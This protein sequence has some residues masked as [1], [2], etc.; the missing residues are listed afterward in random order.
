MQ[1]EAAQRGWIQGDAQAMYNSAVEESFIWLGVTD[2]VA[3]ADDY[4]ASGNSIV[5]W[6]AATDKTKL[7]VMQKYLALVGVNNF[8]AWVDYRRLGVPDVP[9]SLSPSRGNNKIPLRLKYPQDEYNYNAANVAAENNP[10]PQSSG[11]FWD[12]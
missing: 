9:L 3:T 5:D 8:E 4:L 1:A 7:I 11:I 12:K 10:D 6:D 2:A